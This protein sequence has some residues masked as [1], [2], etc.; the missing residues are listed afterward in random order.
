M[1]ASLSLGRVQGVGSPRQPGV[2]AP[3]P[4]AALE[5]HDRHLPGGKDGSGA[6]TFDVS[7]G[8]YVVIAISFLYPLQHLSFG[9]P[10]QVRDGFLEPFFG[11]P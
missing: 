10:R 6:D 4:Q 8:W 11:L 2:Q 3:I 7:R 9:E 1:V 5:S